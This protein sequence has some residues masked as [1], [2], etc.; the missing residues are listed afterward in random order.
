MNAG[1][2][3]GYEGSTGMSTG[4]HVHYEVRNAT[5]KSVDGF[6][7][8]EKSSA[9]RQE[10]PASKQVNIRINTRNNLKRQGYSMEDQELNYIN[11]ISSSKTFDKDDAA[12]CGRS[13]G[14][15]SQN[16]NNLDPKSDYHKATVY[17]YEYALL[18]DKI[19]GNKDS[20]IAAMYP[21]VTF[22]FKS[23]TVSVPGM[24]NLT[25]KQILMK[26]KAGM[27]KNI[28]NKGYWAPDNISRYDYARRVY[29]E[30]K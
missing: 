8:V 15:A 19:F 24:S 12:I 4:P 6:S 11:K 22:T 14:P 26:Y 1:Y 10:D 27:L 25:A 7:L 23:K 2:L 28:L 30:T 29:T 5:G 17:A 3:I 9:T 21:G 13:F 20:A 16:V 18:R